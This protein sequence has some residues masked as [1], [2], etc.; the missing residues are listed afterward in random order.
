MPMSSFSSPGLLRATWIK[1]SQ[2]G[3]K[4]REVWAQICAGCTISARCCLPLTVAGCLGES[5]SATVLF[6]FTSDNT[7]K[8]GV[9]AWEVSP[10]RQGERR[11]GVL[12]EAQCLQPG[13]PSVPKTEQEEFLFRIFIYFPKLVF[14]FKL[15]CS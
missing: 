13:T 4:A 9:Q 5:P 6:S 8:R 7:W 2:S 1:C 3:T 15:N 14:F 10:V 11:D 12:S